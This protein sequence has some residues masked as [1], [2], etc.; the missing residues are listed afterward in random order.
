MRMRDEQPDDDR[1]L[2]LVA[3]DDADLRQ[4][5]VRVLGE[6]YRT[7]AVG[8]GATALTAA[9]AQTPDVILTGLMLPPLDGVGLMA[10]LRADPRTSGVPVIMLTADA[11]EDTTVDG[12]Q[13]GADD[14]LVQPFG[15]GELLA[16][17]AIHLK[18]ARLCRESSAA[19]QASADQFRALVNASSDVVYRMNADWTELRHLQGRE[20]I[21][22]AHEPNRSWLEKYIHPDDR[23]LVT[24]TIHVAVRSK[25]PF[26][27]EHQVVRTDGTLGWTFSR[28][29]P[30]LD[31]DG[32]VIEWLGMASDVTVRKQAQV[33]LRES[34]QEYHALFESMD[35]GYCVIEMIFDAD[36]R[37]IDYRF[38][39]VNPAFEQHT[40]I[41]NAQGQRMREIAPD[42]EVRWFEIYGRVAVTGEAIRF[43]DQAKGLGNRWFDVYAFRLG[44]SESHTVAI[45]FSDISARIA[46]EGTLKASEDRSRSI[47]D[48]ITD[49]FFALDK[50]WRLTFINAAAGQMMDR[51]PSDL[52]GERLLDVYPDLVGSEF[53]QAYRRVLARQT[54]ETF[55]AYY[56]NFDRWYEV[57][58]Y[59]ALTGLSLYFRDVT[60]RRRVEHEREQFAA[61]VEASPDFISVAGLDQRIRYVNQAGTALS[62]LTPDQLASISV[63][64]F[65]H[66]DER[67]RIGS[68]IAGSENGEQVVVD[69][70]FQHLQ[71]GELIPVS[72]SLLRLRDTSGNVNGYATVTRDLTER[73]AAEILLRASEERR[74]L[75]L[76]AAELG[77]WH[78]EPESR[79]VQTDAR[80]RAIFGATEEMSDFLQLFAVIH[81][82]D[83]SAVE[84]ALAMATRLEDPTPY[85]VEYRVV[86][87]DGSLHWI[88]AKGRSSVDGVGATRR[89]T[90]FDGTV[91][92]ITDR[93]QGEEERERLVARLQEQDQRKDEF[94]AT[95]AHELRNPLA[96]IRNGLQLMRLTQGD[97]D[98]SE[99]TRSMM[100]RQVGQ[101]VH[102]LDDLLDVSRISRGKIS[103]RK[104][105]IELTSAIAQAIEISRPF[106]DQGGHELV[107]DVPPGP[108]HVD[109]DLTRLAQVFSNVLNNAAK[110]TPREGHIRL[111]VQQLGSDAVVSVTD[112]GMGIPTDMLSKIF[113]M[114]THV[115]R[116]LERSQSGLG[117]GLS[118]VRR[119]VELHGGSV[120]ARSDGDGQGSEL[121]VRLPVDLSGVGPE[122]LDEATVARPTAAYRILVVDDNVDS[123]ESL[124]TLLTIMGHE[125]RMAHDGLEAVDVAEAFRPTVMMLDI[126]LPKLDGVEV[127]RRIR[128]QAWG[129]DIVVIA[130]TGWGQDADKRRTL[131]AGADAHL[132]KPVAPA[133]LEQLLAELTVSSN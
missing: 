79:V 96:P 129:K 38:L 42:H 80:F 67:D 123:A 131:D 47:L 94:L 100:E 60:D 40:G 121:I 116:N 126:G 86:H 24:E 76:D 50:D 91:A 41:R 95:L 44:S 49:G 83:V 127:C 70:H 111:T 66:E 13:R 93:K 25:G 132:V 118:I 7:E 48:S 19:I 11:G 18:M 92:D 78:L 64:D 8:D 115:E 75:A 32:A 89:V 10:A 30:L 53:E 4:Y 16:R 130:L 39:Q 73:N 9:L 3:D 125:T 15:A 45:L 124:A 14:F 17:V 55:T 29:I 97:A 113:E 82:D 36:S 122:P 74:R 105:R 63:R 20:F 57:S 1:P 72:W 33:A 37:P 68:L 6:L 21:A 120:E 43:V 107:V 110:Y 98:A 81:P 101:M 117:I 46:A 84:E 103:L 5:I 90:S 88:F 87:P 59:P 54:A 58:A 85:A 102:L 27:L 128:Q 71:T 34:E 108:I 77:T 99:R 52:I 69:S 56:L 31:T 23:R 119:L 22:D 114:F 26:E 28:A 35:Q 133:A 61:L 109:G 112:D 2:V 65:F 106:I 51:A 12:L 62:G 104:E